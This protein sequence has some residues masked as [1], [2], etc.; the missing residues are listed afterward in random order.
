MPARS[1]ALTTS[2]PLVPL[3]FNYVSERPAAIERVSM[4]PRTL[5]VSGAAF[6]TRAGAQD[7]FDK[8]DKSLLPL[9]T[10]GDITEY[11]VIT[12]DENGLEFQHKLSLGE[13]NKKLKVDNKSLMHRVQDLEKANQDAA[14]EKEDAVRANQDADRVIFQWEMA[15]KALQAFGRLLSADPSAISEDTRAAMVHH[16]IKD[17]LRYLSLQHR[18]YQN[19][20]NQQTHA[21]SI[22]YASIPIHY[23]QILENLV[24]AKAAISEDRARIAHPSVRK[25]DVA[26]FLAPY[27]EQQINP[28]T[29]LLKAMQDV[30][31]MHHLTGDLVPLFVEG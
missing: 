3:A 5:T 19:E 16:S 14:R 26:G 4:P 31:V 13:R 23:R 28:A 1:Y 20:R 2:H 22:A 29:E 11:R 18:N 10:S 25:S 7:C 15:T 27:I 21:A 8:G 9:S 24:H 6:S 12:L 17:D 30:K